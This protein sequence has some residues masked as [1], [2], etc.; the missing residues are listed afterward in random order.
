MELEPERIKSSLTADQYKLYKL[1]WERFIASL[2]AHCIHDT[3]NA[4]ITCDTRTKPMRRQL[5][6]RRLSSTTMTAP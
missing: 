1:V 2:M 5:S 6:M 4:E 3:T